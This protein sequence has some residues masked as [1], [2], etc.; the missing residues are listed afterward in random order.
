MEKKANYFF[1]DVVAKSP[2]MVSVL[3]MAQKLAKTD[4][5][6]HLY[7]DTG[8]GK[9]MLAQAIHNGSHVRGGPYLSVN[10][11]ARSGDTLEKELFGTENDQGVSPGL[12]EYANGG[13]L[14]I[15][16]V[17]EL[18]A[19]GQSRLL[20]IFE[21]KRV[22]RIGGSLSTPVNIRVITTSSTDLSALAKKGTF[23]RDLYYHLSALAINIPSLCERTEDIPFLIDHYLKQHLGKTD[24]TITHDAMQT[25]IHYSWPGNVREL[26][27]VVSHLA[28]LDEKTVDSS[29][30]P[31][32]VKKEEQE[33]RF[34]H[35]FAQ[36][37]DEKQI[38][39]K[40]EEHGFL[41]ESLEI[42][43]I[44]ERGKRVHT[45]F[46]RLAVKKILNERG[47]KL[48]EQ[49][50]RLRLEVLHELGLL[51]VRQGRSGTTI[52]RKGEQFLKKIEA[53]LKA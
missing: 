9:S 38:I 36:Q 33:K 10:C 43:R 32:N 2:S 11:A 3:N 41:E 15:E 8:T 23:R 42:L 49:Q 21:E 53:M 50:L 27:N 26:Y 1:A 48:S 34:H 35:H 5:P 22:T 19:S 29:A 51:N 13:T 25:L 24:L 16:E 14:C 45:S 4:S 31:L 52:S 30:L 20:Q 37:I 6:V 47:F 46:G 40:I 17:N 39:Q 28:C 12:F 18:S 44:F 7:G